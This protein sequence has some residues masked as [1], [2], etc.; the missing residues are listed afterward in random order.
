MPSTCIISK[1]SESLDTDLTIIKIDLRLERIEQGQARTNHELNIPVK[2]KIDFRSIE[3]A[4]NFSLTNFYKDLFLHSSQTRNGSLTLRSYLLFR[5]SA[6]LASIATT[7][8]VITIKL[9]SSLTRHYF[10]LSLIFIRLTSR[11]L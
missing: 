8:S 2:K 4:Y 6:L 1:E 7:S 3:V 9:A 10:I 5:R 11:K